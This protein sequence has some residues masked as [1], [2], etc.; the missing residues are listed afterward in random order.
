[1]HTCTS[2]QVCM[3][4]TLGLG[5]D[6]K[7]VMRGLARTAPPRCRRLHRY[8]MLEVYYNATGGW[9]LGSSF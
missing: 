7:L 2:V 9:R 1:M 4:C 5:T 8:T 6:N 3:L